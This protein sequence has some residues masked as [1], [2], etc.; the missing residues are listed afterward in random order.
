V[1]P[2][3]VSGGALPAGGLLELPE[4]ELTERDLED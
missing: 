4:I 1:Q 3:D 2:V